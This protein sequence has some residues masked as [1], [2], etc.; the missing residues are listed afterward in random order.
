MASEWGYKNQNSS[1]RDK[2]RWNFDQGKGNLVRVSGSSSQRKFELSSF[3]CSTNSNRKLKQRRR[4]RQQERQKSNR[5]RLVKQQLC[6]CTTLFLYIFLHDYKVKVPKFKFCR[7]QE[8]KTT[9]F[10][11]LFLNFDT[12]LQNSTLKTFANIWRSKR[13]GISAIKLEATRIHFLKWRFRCRRRR[14]CVSS[15]MQ[16]CLIS[17]FVEDGNTRQKL[18]FSFSELWYSSLEFNSKKIANIWRIK[19]DGISAKKF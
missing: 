16:K 14:C 12:V 10:L 4:R 7:G 18:S 6:K 19:R 1:H 17:R 15:L 3:Y 8:H 5:F 11:F 13:D 2:F 9:T